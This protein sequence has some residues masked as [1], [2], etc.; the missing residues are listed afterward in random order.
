[1]ENASKALIIAGAILL[2]IV[3]ISLGLIVINNV[4]NTVDTS[5][6]SEQEIQMF[7]TKFVSYEGNNIVASRVNSLIQ[8]VF[9]TN[10]E[11]RQKGGNHF[12]TIGF[13]P[14]NFSDSWYAWLT[15]KADN[16]YWVGTTK[17]FIE[18]TNNPSAGVYSGVDTN[19]TRKLGEPASDSMP[20]PQL[21]VK[22]GK[23]Y[24]VK[25]PTYTDGLVKVITVV[26][27]P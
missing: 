21:S 2:A 3:I 9:A 25:I 1:M 13:K 14:V 6:L 27:N 4:R 15:T 7:N 8:Q 12:V 10:Q 18:G 22:T 20:S 24:T 5:N 11:T 26:E 19:I 16:N 23:S 17:D